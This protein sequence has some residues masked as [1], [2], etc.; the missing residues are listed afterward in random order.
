MLA[1]HEKCL[2]TVGFVG[3]SGSVDI[4]QG[5]QKQLFAF[6]HQ[7][8]LSVVSE[9]TQLQAR[10]VSPAGTEVKPESEFWPE[11]SGDCS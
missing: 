6:L 1:S 2:L 3:N 7:E 9:C 11:D 5:M 8:F 10:A 4:P